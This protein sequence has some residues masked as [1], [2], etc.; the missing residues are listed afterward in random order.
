MYIESYVNFAGTNYQTIVDA[1][2]NALLEAEV[3]TQISPGVLKIGNCDHLLKVYYPGSG[4]E[5]K[6]ELRNIANTA[7]LQAENLVLANSGNVVIK[8]VHSLE[9]FG[10]TFYYTGYTND[11]VEIVTLKGVDR[12]NSDT[13]AVYVGGTL[14]FYV[15]GSDVVHKLTNTNL[16]YEGPSGYKASVTLVYNNASKI[17]AAKINLLAGHDFLGALTSGGIAANTIVRLDNSYYLWKSKIDN[18]YV[19]DRISGS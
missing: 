5:I 3:V 15:N 6:I 14:I 2:I 4:S 1:M 8:M 16:V 7:V 9:G 19:T 12:Q 17:F 10:A 18:I 13:W 11:Y